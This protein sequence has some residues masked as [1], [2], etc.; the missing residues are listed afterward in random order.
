MENI[1]CPHTRWTYLW[2]ETAGEPPQPE[3]APSHPSGCNT[4]WTEAHLFPPAEAVPPG[5]QHH[6]SCGFRQ[7]MESCSS[8]AVGS[9]AL[10]AVLQFL[11]PWFTSAFIQWQ[12][13][14]QKGAK[15]PS[16]G[17][18]LVS[19]R[20]AYP[21]ATLS[22]LSELQDRAWVLPSLIKDNITAYNCTWIVTGTYLLFRI[23]P[24]LFR[25]VAYFRI[26]NAWFAAA[27]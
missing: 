22:D 4:C 7:G 26:A 1:L 23:L 20:A 2:G 13:G 21:S 16:K 12:H 19:C 6:R 25:I 10:V 14:P 27:L 11:T 9:S 18:L 8:S 5:R 24:L 15:A 3:H 17:S